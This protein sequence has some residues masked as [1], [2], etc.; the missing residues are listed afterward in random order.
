MSKSNDDLKQMLIPKEDLTLK[1]AFDLPKKSY[2]Y[3]AS[4]NPQEWQER[5]REKLKQLIVC[6]FNFDKREVK[7][8][9]TTNMDFGVVHSL[10]MQVSDNLSIPAY[11]FIPHEIKSEVAVIAVQGHG[12]VTGVLGITD[13]Y[14]HGFGRELCRAGHVVLVPE[15]RGFGDIVDLSAH[16]EGRRLVYYNWGELMAFPLVTDAFLKGYTLIGDTV[17]DLYAWGTYLCEYTN[18]QNYAIAG[19]SYGGDLALIL[20]ALDNRVEKTFASGTLGSMTT[21]F[22]KCYNAPAHCIPSI[23]K[24][25]DRQEIA[26]CIAP[27]SLCVHYGELDVPSPENSSAAYNETAMPAYTGVENFFGVLNAKDKLQL[28]I[29]PNMNHEMDNTA[30]ITYLERF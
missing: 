3:E 30:L 12:Y 24:Y 8:H 27:R 29:S 10:I 18:Q 14:H 17:Q 28:V 25:M 2:A 21:I 20:A 4:E 7:V 26:S 23:L 6:D 1:Y 13:D 22:E 9:H 11:L 19:I 15:I 16:D 5:C